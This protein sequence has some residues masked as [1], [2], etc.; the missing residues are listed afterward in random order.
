MFWVGVAEGNGR[1]G[2]VYRLG[3]DVLFFYRGW[4]VFSEEIEVEAI[5]DAD[6]LLALRGVVA[7]FG[8]FANDAGPEESPGLLEVGDEIV[9]FVAGTDNTNMNGDVTVRGADGLDGRDLHATW[10]NSFHGFHGE[11]PGKGFFIE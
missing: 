3:G 8:V 2:V 5:G 10:K 6:G 1:G 7:G 11:G 9:G 4:I